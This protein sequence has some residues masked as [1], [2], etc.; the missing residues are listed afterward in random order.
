MF[1]GLIE[2]IGTLQDVRSDREGRR[3]RIAAPRTVAGLAI[4]ESVAC[5]GI[6]LTV[7][8]TDVTRGVFQVAAVA[9][10]LRRTTAS[11][12]LRG[13]RLHLERALAAGER[14][15]GHLVQGHVDGTARVVR[16]GREGR[17]FV[18][19]IDLP[20][21]L[22]RYV[23][24]QGSLAVDGV[25][26][27]VGALRGAQCRLF[28]IPHTLEQTCLGAYRPGEWVNLETDL[29]A[30]YVAAVGPGRASARAHPAP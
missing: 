30:K 12:W 2:E 22:R 25:S 4:G 8:E 28:I 17:D 13:Q 5:H 21:A 10:T 29:V 14:L 19:T 23:I 1:T 15:G 11:R 24:P 26:L 9:E 20:A 27:T 6:C 3:L 18:L 16:A 7:E